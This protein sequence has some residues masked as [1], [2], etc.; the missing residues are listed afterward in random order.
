MNFDVIPELK[1]QHG[2]AIAAV[3]TLVSTLATWWYFK[4]KKW[5]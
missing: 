5:F 4:K 1:W 2:Y 3:V